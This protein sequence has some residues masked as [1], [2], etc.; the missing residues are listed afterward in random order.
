MLVL[1]LLG[2]LLS[3]L[4]GFAAVPHEQAAPAY[5]EEQTLLQLEQGQGRPG[6]AQGESGIEHQDRHTLVPPGRQGEY[7]VILQ[8][9]GNSWRLLRNGPLAT[10]TAALLLLTALGILLYHLVRRPQPNV[11]DEPGHTRRVLRFTRWQRWVHWVAA[12]AFIALPISG[13]AILFGKKLLLPWLG[14]EVFAWLALGSKW[15]H[16]VA[17]PLFIVATVVMFATYLRHNHLERVDWTWLRK[18]GGLFS[19]QHVAAPY[20]NAGEKLWFWL[21]VTALGGVMA[22][23]GLM[24]N[25]PYLGEVGAVLALTRY[26]LQVAHVI[27]LVGATLYV[28]MSLGHIYVGSAGSPDAW[29]AMTRGDVSEA[30]A[31]THH[32]LWFDQ[33]QR[34]AGMPTPPVPAQGNRR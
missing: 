2:S 25:F 3:P 27:H 29:Q 31:H 24:L 4:Q 23:S 5:A 13:L 7:G 19:G 17:G 14:H 20:F 30:W 10:A 33:V 32:R 11:A 34:D 16:N 15:L 8:R 21:G 18:A 9:G 1:T 28:A 26:E 12:I 6:W 22:V